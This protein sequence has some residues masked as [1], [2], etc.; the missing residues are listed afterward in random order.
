MIL[1]KTTRQ[2]HNQNQNR[3]YSVT[4][5]RGDKTKKQRPMM[6]N[7]D[8]K[9]IAQPTPFL[10]GSSI[11]ESSFRAPKSHQPLLPVCHIYSLHIKML[12]PRYDQLQSH[13]VS[14]MNWC[15]NEEIKNDNRKPS[16][17]SSRHRKYRHPSKTQEVLTF[18]FTY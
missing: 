1:S 8:T 3:H 16:L 13:V 5:K 11:N 4:M 6:S 14:R 17:L 15:K 7:R 2:N 12:L 9:C 10:F 18:N